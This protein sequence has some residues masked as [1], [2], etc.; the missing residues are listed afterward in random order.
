MAAHCNTKDLVEDSGKGF[1]FSA[2]GRTGNLSLFKK[3][4]DL[5]IFIF[6]CAGSLLWHVGFL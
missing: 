6:G 1:P 5:F 4:I 3:K 2:S